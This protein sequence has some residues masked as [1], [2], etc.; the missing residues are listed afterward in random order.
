[1]VVAERAGI[2]LGMH[3]ASTSPAEIT[4]VQNMLATVKVPR[5]HGGAP[6]RK[7][8]RLIAAVNTAP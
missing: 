8:E 6:R 4:L 2:P 3:I 5:K 1:M 7:P